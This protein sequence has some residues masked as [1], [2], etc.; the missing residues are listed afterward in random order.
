[1]AG[2]YACSNERGTMAMASR[3]P[4]SELF[5]G[6]DARS[7]LLRIDCRTAARTAMAEFSEIRVG[8]AEPAGWA[9]SIQAPTSLSP[10]VKLVAPG[11]QSAPGEGIEVAV[12]R[13]LEVRV[14]LDQLGLKAGDPLHFFVE[15]FAA[16][17]SQARAPQE[18]VITLTCPA[19]D[20]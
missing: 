3:S 17:Q 15:G 4:F 13:I 8:F 11:G 16:S 1:G 9:L 5:F 18:G 7:F 6:F 20:F 10:P 12:D 14:P 19:G 2:C